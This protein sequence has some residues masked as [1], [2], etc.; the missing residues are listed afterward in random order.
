MIDDFSM[1][2]KQIVFAARFKA[3]QRGANLIDTGDFLL[4]LILED[5][6]RLGESLFSNLHDGHGTFLNKAPSHIPFFSQKEA[7]DLVTE[8]EALQTKAKP[9]G[10]STE[11]P[12]SPA[13]ERAF[14]L[15]K[16][17]QARLHHS[18]IEP[19]HLLAAILTE[20]FGQC[21][22]LLEEFGITRE[23]VLEQLRGTTET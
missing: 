9:V 13:L 21:V 1:R 20:E 5:Q 12:L 4:G 19:L 18:Q 6:G 10:L 23:R 11:I 17:F 3:G 16:D 14:G 2:A 22:K 15:A 7:E 8:I